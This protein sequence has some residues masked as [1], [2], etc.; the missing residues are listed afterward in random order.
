MQEHVLLH[1]RQSSTQNKKYQ[2]SQ[3]HSCFSW[4]W[5]HSRPKHVEIN[6]YTKNKLFTKL[7]L[8]TRWTKMLSTFCQVSGI[9]MLTALITEQGFIADFRVEISEKDKLTNLHRL[10]L[11]QCMY[12]ASFVISYYFKCSCWQYQQLHLKYLCNLARYLLQSPCGW[13]DAVETCRSVIICEI[14]VHLFVVV[15]NK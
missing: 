6:K 10:F 11:F 9:K 1:T 3:K 13:H 14:I 8:F 15:H 4:W 12:R 7:V 2:V 5:A